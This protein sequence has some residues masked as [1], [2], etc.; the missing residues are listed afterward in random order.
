MRKFTLLIAFLLIAGMQAALAQI[1]VKGTVT[2]AADG[3]PL[4]GVSIIVKGTILGTITDVDGKYLLSVPSGYNELIYSFVGMITQETKIDG[5]TSIDIAMNED[6]VGLEEVV[7]TALGIPREK[8]T[9]GY[10]VQDVKGDQLSESGQTNV[11]NAMSGR[12][13]GVQITSSAGTMGGSSRIL[14]RGANSITGNNAPLFVVDGTIIDNT[15]YNSYNTARGGGGYD[16]GSMAQDL[17]PEDIES[18]SVLKGPTASALYGSRA[19]NGV[20]VITTKKGKLGGKKGIGVTLSTGVTF[21]KVSYLPEYQKLYGG[22][23]MYEGED[24]YNG[25]QVVNIEGKDYLV[26]DYATDE[27]WGPAYSTDLGEYGGV[28]LWNSFDEWD[29]EHY[30]VPRE[31]K[32]PENNV[33][34][35]F[36][37]GVLYTNNVSFT[38]GTDAAAFRLSYTNQTGNGYF[39]GSEQTKHAIN[40]NGEAKLNAKLKAFTSIN[41]IRTNF[42]GRVETGYGDNN[43]MVRINQWGHNHL[44]YE[45]LK[46]YLNPDGTQRTWN[47]TSWDNP[48]PYYSNNQYWS[49]YEDY[50]NDSRDHYFGNIGASYQLFDW[51]T[52]QGKFNLDQYNFKVYERIAVGSM[53]LSSYTETFRNNTELNMEGMFLAYKELNDDWTISGNLGVNQMQRFYENISGV[54]SGG[55]VV[56]DLYNLSNS[57]NPS[58]VTNRQER[59]KINSIFASVTLDYAKMVSVIVTGR[60]DWSSTLPEDN[61]SYFY[62]SVSGSWVFTEL[63][64]L[65]DNKVLP[66]GKLRLSWAKVGNDTDPYRLAYNFIAEDNFGSNP[67]YRLSR[68]LNNPELVPEETN[69]WEIGL[70]LRWFLNRLGIDFTYYDMKTL[71]QI[72][73]VAT[74]ATTG[75]TTQVINAGQMSNKGFEIQLYGTPIKAK[76]KNDFNWDITL[77]FSKNN[78][79]VDSLTE[80]VD[81]YRLGSIFGFEVHAEVGK[82]FGS[83]RSYNFVYDENG[84]KVVGTNGRYV[85]GPIES[86]G[87]VLPD[88]NLGFINDFKWKGFDL[89]ILIDWQKGGS[90]LSLTN[91]WGMYSGILEESAVEN[92]NGNNV[93]DAVDEGGGFLNDGVYGYT[94]L[95]DEGNTVVHWTDA[96]GNDSE[97]PVTNE[98]YIEALRW[99]ADHYSRARGGQNVFGADYIK[100]R[101]VKLGYTFDTKDWGPITGMNVAVYGRNLAIWGRD[102]QHIDPE[103]TTSAGNIQGIEGGQLPGLRSY[104]VNLTFSF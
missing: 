40:F 56:A 102:L 5:R 21:D 36:E 53:F 58:T 22:G 10:A 76:D 57:T 52:L 14:I 35:F 69:S 24:A 32:Y 4:P 92:A 48:A 19:A 98:T 89:S 13:A 91:M 104:G 15:D 61:N 75:Y 12:V 49:R 16:Y 8:R 86:V 46:D 83:L 82:P 20:I 2:D 96:E 38:G 31:W 85:N 77:N 29:T 79:K 43:P 25:F 41:Y 45:E 78:N 60:N 39:P 68:Q 81:S 90:F 63:G 50:Q 66:F 88:F 65:K 9:L 59:K 47:R 3:T 44:D 103:F 64:G 23:T 33:E 1:E 17:N 30:L 71:N 70:D 26:H 84:N 99:G 97:V 27:S 95:D 6:V 74:S 42:T 51:L 93:R 80:G 18:V 72:I 73:P 87:S 54:T 37:T 67:N 28:L 55:L 34:S 94:S 11:I 62:P 100:L 101:E 7:V